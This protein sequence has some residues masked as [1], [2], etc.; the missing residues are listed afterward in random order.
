MIMKKKIFTLIE[1]LVVIAIIAILASMLLPVLNK[2][3]EK[4]K[5][6]SCLSNL[7]QMGLY[8]SL[9][10][11]NN[12]G[13][14]PL[15]QDRTQSPWYWWFDA[16]ADNIGSGFN[17]KV[18]FCPAETQK[19]VKTNYGMDSEWERKTSLTTVVA[20]RKLNR[21]KRASYLFLTMD[22]KREDLGGYYKIWLERYAPE[23][24]Q[25]ITNILFA[26]GHV[27]GMKPRSFGLLGG[28]I[29]GWS[30]DDSRWRPY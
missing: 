26:D 21:I 28:S 2:A 4:A 1:L 18:L 13:F 25:K 23:R 19:G 11:D 27:R 7:K 15:Q 16:L 5:S 10:N 8:F 9:Y 6:I 24:H 3:R 29:A 22:S 30:R 14:F 12:D 17:N 20:P